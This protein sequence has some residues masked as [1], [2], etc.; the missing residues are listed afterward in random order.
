MKDPPTSFYL[1]QG[2][3][4]LACSVNLQEPRVSILC[5]LDGYFFL[6]LWFLGREEREGGGDCDFI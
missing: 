3:L 2:N 1:L 5:F 4:G 6:F